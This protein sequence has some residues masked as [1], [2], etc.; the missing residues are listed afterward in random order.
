MSRFKRMLCALLALLCAASLTGCG[1]ERQDA[2]V[3]LTLWYAESECSREAMT[4]LLDRFREESGL[5]VDAVAFSDE[6]ALGAAFENRRPDLL[7]CSLDRAAR[8]DAVEPLSA[9]P[10]HRTRD[11]NIDAASS[12]IPDG[13]FYPVGGRLPLL[14]V[15]RDLADP[16]FP[17]LETLARVAADR[18]SPFLGAES[19]ADLLYQALFSLGQELDGREK[20]D[21]R[22]EVYRA[23]YNTLAA[24]AYEGGLA[25][26]SDNA[27]AYVRQGLLSCAAVSSTA[28]VGQ[29]DAH[30]AIRTLPVP[31]GGADCWSAE[32]MGFAA[33]S[34]RSS[35]VTF[36]EWLTDERAASLA[37]SAGLAPLTEVGADVPSGQLETLLCALQQGGF[38]RWR[39]AGGAF[40]AN[41][42]DCEQSLRR[43]L[44]L[45]A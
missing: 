11:E 4:A 10:I 23:V 17:D 34:G 24:A 32:L 41:R 7:F 12:L 15:N 37:L 38:L 13:V 45:L 31:A 20:V 30:L 3:D 27:A 1:R 36:L 42:A 2:A 22:S 8:M 29:A 43:H 26:V 6:D 39:P 33:L 35:A 5:T 21:S 9:L 14:L 28:L 40:D 44:D 25:D 18:R 16:V 19:W